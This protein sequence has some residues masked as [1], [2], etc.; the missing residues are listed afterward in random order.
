MLP[1]E[2]TKRYRYQGPPLGM[3]PAALIRKRRQ[4]RPAAI[5]MT[6]VEFAKLALMILG[7]D[8][9]LIRGIRANGSYMLY[10]MFR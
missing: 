1:R 3:R 2:K 5:Y 7:L 8:V 10:R 6:R 4:P 9:N